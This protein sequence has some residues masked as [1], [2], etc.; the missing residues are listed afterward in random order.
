MTS[1]R[2]KRRKQKIK[3]NNGIDLKTRRNNYINK[4]GKKATYLQFLKD[5]EVA[6]VKDIVFSACIKNDINLNKL[7][8]VEDVFSG[9]H[10]DNIDNK[11][12]FDLQY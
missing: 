10:G 1:Y 9:G 12:G 4:T 11:E 2:Y 7:L 5:D 3:D 6:V 8:Y